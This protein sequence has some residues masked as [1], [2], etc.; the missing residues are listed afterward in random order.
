MVAEPTCIHGI[1]S[2]SRE[3]IIYE[4]TVNTF[5][6]TRPPCI[7]F[8]TYN[9]NRWKSPFLHDVLTIHP[10]VIIHNE[11][12]QNFYYLPPKRFLQNDSED[13]LRGKL[14]QLRERKR[15]EEQLIKAKEQAIGST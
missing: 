8:C 7:G 6:D 15:V 3:W 9:R 2:L 14:E 11:L 12:F 1:E 13:L 10:Q 5:F 4:T